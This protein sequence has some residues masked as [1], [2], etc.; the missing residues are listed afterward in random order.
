MAIPHGGLKLAIDLRLKVNTGSGRDLLYAAA[1]S[2]Y[3]FRWR[4]CPHPCDDDLFQF[5]QGM[6]VGAAELCGQRRQNFFFVA[7]QEPRTG[8]ESLLSCGGLGGFCFLRD[9]IL[10]FFAYRTFR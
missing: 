5:G 9:I 6:P 10:F 3:F 7:I 4:L 2:R 8:R 1:S